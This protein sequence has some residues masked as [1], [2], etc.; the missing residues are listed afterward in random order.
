MNVI[1][2][3]DRIYIIISIVVF[4]FSAALFYVETEYPEGNVL[5]SKWTQQNPEYTSWDLKHGNE[6]R[7]WHNKKKGLRRS[8]FD[9]FIPGPPS[10]ILPTPIHIRI[11]FSLFVGLAVSAMCFL[12]LAALSRS[13]RLMLRW[14]AS[15]FKG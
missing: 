2:G 11:A 14:V 5:L 12:I 13:V 4:C 3:L 10:K 8:V 6:W 1:K 15:G 9:L 7:A